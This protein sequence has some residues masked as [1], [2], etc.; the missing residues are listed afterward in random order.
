MMSTQPRK[1]KRSQSPS[2]SDSEQ[3]HRSPSS[4]SRTPQHKSSGKPSRSITSSSSTS[5]SE[6][7]QSQSSIESF[8]LRSP[9]SSTYSSQQTASPQSGRF[10]SSSSSS[11][12]SSSHLR[13]SGFEQSQSSSVSSVPRLKQQ[14]SRVCPKLNGELLPGDSAAHIT[15][16]MDESFFLNTLVS[17]FED[18][19]SAPDRFAFRGPPEASDNSL[20]SLEKSLNLGDTSY[21]QEPILICAIPAKDGDGEP[22]MSFDA[23]EKRITHRDDLFTPEDNRGVSLV[24]YFVIDGERRIFLIRQ[25]RIT[26]KSLNAVIFWN[27]K[28]VDIYALYAWSKRTPANKPLSTFESA[29]LVRALVERTLPESHR[30]NIAKRNGKISTLLP[31]IADGSRIMAI[32]RAPEQNWKKFT[33][34]MECR[35]ASV[36]GLWSLRIT[37]RD[38]SQSTKKF[39]AAQQLRAYRCVLEEDNKLTQ[40][41]ATRIKAKVISDPEAGALS[42]PEPEED[43][44]SGGELAP[45]SPE[46]VPESPNNCLPESAFSEYSGGAEEVAHLGAALPFR[47]RRVAV[48]QNRIEFLDVELP[49]ADGE[50]DK[51][52]RAVLDPVTNILSLK[53]SDDPEEPAKLAKLNLS[54]SFV[55]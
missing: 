36:R 38:R 26:V 19:K 23:F 47:Y 48:D 54:I 30:Y 1:R 42:S 8:E 49:D 41:I 44:E 31:S 9:T 17:K 21:L 18:I 15:A 22:I 3:A 40:E 24:T 32:A 7:E 46:D 13:E 20:K 12:F 16:L 50:T 53:K 33:E 11:S 39:S 43:I 5:K 25:T 6:M 4:I 29:T 34:I 51:F 35:G 52:H 45:G 10:A 14:T 55:E 2:V 27:L 28:D 37:S